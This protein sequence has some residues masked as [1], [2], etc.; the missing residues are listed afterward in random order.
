MSINLMSTPITYTDNNAKNI[1]ANKRSVASSFE[2]ALKNAIAEKSGIVANTAISNSVI[3][4]ADKSA[5]SCG[6]E[7]D[8][9]GNVVELCSDHE[10]GTDSTITMTCS[11]CLKKDECGHYLNGGPELTF[12]VSKESAVSHGLLPLETGNKQMSG[13]KQSACP[14]CGSMISEDGACPMCSVSFAY[15]TDIRR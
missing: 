10:E 2:S 14:V 12:T 7:I 3:T 13:I 11:D 5:T 1:A 6:C 15:R 9:E 8:D 4:D